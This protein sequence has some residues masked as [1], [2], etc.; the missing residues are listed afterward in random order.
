MPSMTHFLAIAEF[1]RLPIHLHWHG[2]HFAVLLY[3]AGHLGGASLR[4]GG[5]PLPS[6]HRLLRAEE[7]KDDDG[8]SDGG[9]LLGEKE[10]KLAAI[11]CDG[12]D[13]WQWARVAELT[14]QLISA[15]DF[16]CIVFTNFIHILRSVS[17]MNFAVIAT[18]ILIPQTMLPK[19]SW[20]L[21]AFFAVCTLL[22]QLLNSRIFFYSEKIVTVHAIAPLFNILFSEFIEDDKQRY[23]RKNPVSSLVFSLN[24]LHYCSQSRP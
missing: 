19:G 4:G 9:G 15:K 11:D 17:H 16:Q 14:K 10:D 18:D 12:T 22:P 3:M 8:I 6:G 7:D 1:W 21:S 13:T 2:H 24:A 20:Q 5:V 23:A